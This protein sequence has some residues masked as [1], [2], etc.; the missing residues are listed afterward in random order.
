MGSRGVLFIKRNK[1]KFKIYKGKWLFF[2]ERAEDYVV[3]PVDQ[4][5][6][7]DWRRE[8]QNVTPWDL[9]DY[10]GPTMYEPSDW[11]G[12]STVKE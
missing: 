6:L 11:R 2:Y 10:N 1:T 5:E 8:G 9:V 7:G 4:S 3:G 12:R